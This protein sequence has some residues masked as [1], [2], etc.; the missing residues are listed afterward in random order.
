[1]GKRI[2]RGRSGRQGIK[3]F[4]HREHGGLKEGTEV[5]LDPAVKPRDDEIFYCHPERRERQ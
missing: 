5:L 1:M 4:D 3:P 2:G